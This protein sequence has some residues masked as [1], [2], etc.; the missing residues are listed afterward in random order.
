MGGNKIS[1]ASRR[2]PR[3]FTIIELMVALAVAGILLAMAAPSFRTV[4][5][6][7][8][9]SSTATDLVTALHTARAQA[10]NLRGDVTL[11]ARGEGWSEGWVIAYPS[12]PTEQEQ[13]FTP[14]GGVAVSE[15]GGLTELTFQASGMI[16]NEAEFLVC[17]GRS[18]ET[19]RHITLGRFGTISNDDLDCDQGP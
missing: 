12:F 14:A 7:N 17:D 9:L 16:D 13:T 19:G 10:V 8:A 3:G 11:S 6:N 5:A 2:G 18:G 4:T 15:R 1:N